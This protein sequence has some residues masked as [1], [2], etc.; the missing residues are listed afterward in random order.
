MFQAMKIKPWTIVQ[1]RLH[2]PLPQGGR[3]VLQPKSGSL[4]ALPRLKAM[5][6]KEL[7]H[8]ATL[9]SQ[10]SIYL[11]LAQTPSKGSQ[12][13]VFE[14]DVVEVFPVGSPESIGSVE[15]VCIQDSDVVTEILPP[16]QTNKT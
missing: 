16:S 3:I 12:S 10:T 9:T 7:R 13:D 5:L 8:Y 14:I 1:C 6:E 11:N 2:P 4:S 15:A